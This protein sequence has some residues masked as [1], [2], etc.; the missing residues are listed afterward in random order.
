M[1][2]ERSGALAAWKQGTKT[3]V[4]RDHLGETVHCARPP[5]KAQKGWVGT[6]TVTT[7]RYFFG[8]EGTSEAIKAWGAPGEMV[9]GS[10]H[11]TDLM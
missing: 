5:A 7:E 8:R 11:L 2:S 9:L 4:A 6:G 3:K 1:V 10:A